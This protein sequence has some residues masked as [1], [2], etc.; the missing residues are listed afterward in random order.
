MEPPSESEHQF[1]V[2]QPYDAR[3]EEFGTPRSGPSASVS[4]TSGKYRGE[5]GTQA[6]IS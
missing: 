6:H 4:E 3:S 1:P 2:E 5:S